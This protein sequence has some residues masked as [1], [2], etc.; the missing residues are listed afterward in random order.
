M[1]LESELACPVCLENIGKINCCVT[2][3]NH[4]FHTSC[5]LQCNG[6]CPLCRTKMTAQIQTPVLTNARVNTL[7]EY[8]GN[9]QTL[10]S[11]H[12][13][14]NTLFEYGENPLFGYEDVVHVPQCEL[15]CRQQE[16]WFELELQ[17]QQRQTARH[18]LIRAQEKSWHEA[19]ARHDLFMAQDAQ[20]KAW[21]DMV[22][23]DLK[24]RKKSGC[25]IS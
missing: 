1:E 14:G 21:N 2:A 15:E 25:I 8:G 19:H 18:A 23:R 9:E 17:R 12:N 11:T 7:F 3:C 13:Q 5:L 24:K 6:L 16:E 20:E 22:E 4:T 10:F